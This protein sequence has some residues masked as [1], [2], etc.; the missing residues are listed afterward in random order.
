MRRLLSMAITTT[1]RVRRE[2]RD[3]LSAA[4]RRTGQTA[5]AV[6]DSALAVYERELFWQAW[7]DVH[8]RMTPSERAESE[9]E[10]AV[11]DRAADRDYRASERTVA[12]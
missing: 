4:A 12:S 11:F 10:T 6:I 7:D 9:H 5:D 2:T 1:I 3:R 8:R